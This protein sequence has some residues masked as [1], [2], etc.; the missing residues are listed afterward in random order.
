MAAIRVVSFEA[1]H[2]AQMLCFGGRTAADVLG[3]VANLVR[4]GA[5]GRAM[6]LLTDEEVPRVLGLVFMYLGQE[7]PKVSAMVST[8]AATRM[9]AIV[10][11]MRRLLDES[12]YDVVCAEVPPGWVQDI[13]VLRALGFRRHEAVPLTVMGGQVWSQYVRDR[14]A[15]RLR[16]SEIE[17]EV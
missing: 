3:D 8:L 9:V 10:K 15:L 12:L 16:A 7:K 13:R 1:R 11:V 17:K 2:A 6:S 14:R 5:F 4:L